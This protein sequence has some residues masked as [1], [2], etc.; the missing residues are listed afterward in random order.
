MNN[1]VLSV[2]NKLLDIAIKNSG[3]LEQMKFSTHNLSPAPS[4]INK[5]MQNSLQCQLKATLDNNDFGEVLTACEKKVAV[6]DLFT[7]TLLPAELA[8][9]SQPELLK[10]AITSSRLKTVDLNLLNVTALHEMHTTLK[11]EI[12]TDTLVCECP[13]DKSI[14]KCA[15]L[16]YLINSS[17]VPKTN[18]KPIKKKIFREFNQKHPDN[19]N[20]NGCFDDDDFEQLLAY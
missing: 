13:S 9:N 8:D 6:D 18:K 19:K 20:N 14:S 17:L 15:Y 4:A 7:S 5:S 2:N 16:L 10:N 3:S 1:T 11:T 12:T